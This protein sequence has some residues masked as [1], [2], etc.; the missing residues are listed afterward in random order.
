MDTIPDVV[1]VAD[2]QGV[3]FMTANVEKLLGYTPHEM[4]EM[5]VWLSNMHPDDSKESSNT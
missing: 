1:W 3:P 4:S 5:N 2:A